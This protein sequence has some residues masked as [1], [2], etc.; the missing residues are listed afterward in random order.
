MAAKSA[1]W[2]GVNSGNRR[3]PMCTAGLRASGRQETSS[4]RQTR[5]SGWLSP[6]ARSTTSRCAAAS[7]MIVIRCLAASSAAS[8]RSARRSM[9]G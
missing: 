7:I 9:V 5:I 2:T 8:A 1:A 4:S 6:S 3:V